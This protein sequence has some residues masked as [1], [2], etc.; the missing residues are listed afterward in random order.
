MQNQTNPADT[1]AA[2]SAPVPRFSKQAAALLAGTTTVRS[3]A[4]DA[5]SH[6]MK[7]R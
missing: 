7:F 1:A 2:A 4:L 5:V 6:A 3:N